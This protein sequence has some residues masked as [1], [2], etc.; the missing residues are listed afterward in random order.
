MLKHLEL[1]NFR[2]YEK[3]S[4]DFAKTTILIGP[5]GAGKTNLLE[6]IYL[7]STGRS[8]RTGRDSEVVKWGKDFAKIG[9][10]LKND[11]EIELEM[12]IQ[13]LPTLERPQNKLVKIN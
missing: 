9:G 10:Q 6:A 4:I 2:N 5:N 13:R 7:L 3:Y 11:K 12:I 1:I 8:W